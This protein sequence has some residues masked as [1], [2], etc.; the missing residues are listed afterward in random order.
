MPDSTNSPEVARAKPFALDWSH[1]FG[2]NDRRTV[3]ERM[4]HDT[5][6]IAL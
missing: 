5:V 4:V 1:T 2:L 6:Q 3:E